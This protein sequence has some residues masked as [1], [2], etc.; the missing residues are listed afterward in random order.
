[1]PFNVLIVDDSATTRALIRRTLQLSHLP[2]S[3]YYEAANGQATLD[4]LEC[5]KV[6]LVLADL[7]MPEM[8]GFE[9][10][11]RM[12]AAAATSAIP[13]VLVSAEPNAAEFASRHSNVKGCIR[14]PFT[15]EAVK[16]MVQQF[17]GASDV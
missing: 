14:K 15:P 1:M 10:T 17:M 5:L 9:L 4:L 6:D 3:G 13:V 7:N 12:A 11:R 2:V 8:N 16:Q